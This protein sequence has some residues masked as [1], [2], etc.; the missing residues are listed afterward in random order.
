MATARPGRRWSTCTASSTPCSACRSSPS[1]LTVYRLGAGFHGLGT[2]G[3]V[4]VVAGQPDARAHPRVRRA[5]AALRH[6]TSLVETL[7]DAV[8]WSHHHLGAFPR[9]IVALLGVPALTWGTHMRARRRQGWWVCAF[10]VALTAPVAYALVD[11]GRS[12]RR[13]QPSRRR[14]ACVIGL[15]DRLRADPHRPAAHRPRGAPAGAGRRRPR[16]PRRSG[17]S[18]AA[19]MPC[20][21]RATGSGVPGVS[22][23]FG[24]WRAS[25]RSGSWPRW[26]P[27]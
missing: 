2:R 19:P 17:P 6:R 27:T 7:D 25:R 16:R 24:T 18:P 4:T 26:W 8:R 15:V 3:V 21:D 12:V 10:G 20:G 1:F 9:P 5:A 11:P 23:R 13:G 14:T 22:T